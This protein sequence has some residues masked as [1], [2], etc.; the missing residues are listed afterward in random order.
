M[1]PWFYL[2]SNVEEETV[3]AVIQDRL[4]VNIEQQSF[5]PVHVCPVFTRKLAEELLR[6]VVPVLIVS[7]PDSFLPHDGDILEQSQSVLPSQA[8]KVR[9]V[10][11]LS[12]LDKEPISSLGV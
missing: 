9:I 10:S 3:R 8:F 6:T 1:H 2:D 5:V 4:I 12:S 11:S 7:L